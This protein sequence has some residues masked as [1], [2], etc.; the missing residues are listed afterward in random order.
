MT[1]VNLP[2]A[3]PAPDPVQVPKFQFSAT[4]RSMFTEDNSRVNRKEDAFSFSNFRD[5]VFS[6]LGTWGTAMDYTHN[7]SF[8]YSF[9]FEKIPAPD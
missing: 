7:Y 9:P 5:T 3:Q 8:S 6:Q 2:A 1:T 4:N